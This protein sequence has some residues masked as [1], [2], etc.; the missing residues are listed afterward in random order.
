MHLNTHKDHSFRKLRNNIFLMR[1]VNL[2]KNKGWFSLCAECQ[3]LAFGGLFLRLGVFT[4][5][6]ESVTTS[7]LPFFLFVL[8]KKDPVLAGLKKKL[9]TEVTL[10]IQHCH[11]GHLTYSLRVGSQSQCLIS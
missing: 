9:W 7:Q 6:H 10:G 11:F 3:E 8:K 1:L 2:K 5:L 4:S